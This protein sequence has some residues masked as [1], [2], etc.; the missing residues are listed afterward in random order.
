MTTSGPWSKPPERRTSRRLIPASGPWLWLGFLALVALGLWLLSRWFPV[1]QTAMDQI[2]LIQWFG[3]LALASSGLLY[4]R[5]FK[6]KETARGVALWVAVAACLVLAFS[7]QDQ[8]LGLWHRLRSAV[9]P[10][11]PVQTAPGEMVIS[12]SPGGHYLVYGRI[13]DTPVAFLVDTGASDIVLSP[14]DAK[15]I[16]VDFSTLSFDHVYETANGQGRGAPY[17]VSTLRVGA[18][19]L[20]DVPVSINQAP[21]QT[22]LLGVAF[23]RRLKSFGFG[24]HKMVLR[25]E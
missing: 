18:I 2:G 3:F 6:A 19:V 16:G 24:D 11:Y 17:R 20:H 1:R 13:N 10:G 5:R 25:W 23:L 8:L 21:M 15:R 7:F 12:E 14:A 22:S 9:I 4:V